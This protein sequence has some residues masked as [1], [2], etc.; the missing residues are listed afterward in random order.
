MGASFI[1]LKSFPCK[2]KVI[3]RKCILFIGDAESNP[4]NMFSEKKRF[5]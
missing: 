4:E 1:D 3:Y 5:F 2:D